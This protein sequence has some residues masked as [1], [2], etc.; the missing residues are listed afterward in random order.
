MLPLV[1]AGTA[2]AEPFQLDGVAAL[3]Q[4]GQLAQGPPIF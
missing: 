2:V 3:A 4:Q 1:I